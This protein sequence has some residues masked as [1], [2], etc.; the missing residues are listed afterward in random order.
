MKQ[1][2][3]QKNFHVFSRT[4]F[5]LW[6]GILISLLWNCSDQHASSIHMGNPESPVGPQEYSLGSSETTIA[7]S[8]SS[9]EGESSDTSVSSEPGVSSGYANSSSD[10]PSLSREEGSSSSEDGWGGGSSEID[11]SVPGPA[12][13]VVHLNSPADESFSGRIL[14]FPGNYEPGGAVLLDSLLDGDYLEL[15]PVAQNFPALVQ[16]NILFLPDSQM[17]LAQPES[18]YWAYTVL[19]NIQLLG[20]DTLEVN[21]QPHMLQASETAPESLRIDGDYAEGMFRV[22]GTP[23]YAETLNGLLQ[24]LSPGTYLIENAQGNLVERTVN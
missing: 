3:R 22:A 23:I 20:T 9:A 1:K 10:V 14:L 24:L 18:S 2:I 7:N 17:T 19:Q 15:A 16:V 13:R 4:V 12:L 6:C 21:V 11:V 8:S 5:I